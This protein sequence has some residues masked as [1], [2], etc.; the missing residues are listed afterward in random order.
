MTSPTIQPAQPAQPPPMPAHTSPPRRSGMKRSLKIFGVVSGGLVL[1][2][3]GVGIGAST[4][5]AAIIRTHTVVRTQ[6]VKVPG[7]TVTKTITVK[8][9]G[10]TVTQT[11]GPPPPSAT[12]PGDGTFV[13]GTASADWAPGTWQTSGPSASGDGNCYWATLSDLSGSFNSII[14]ND[15]TA[16]PTTLQ[17]VAGVAG[18][19]VSGCSTWNKIG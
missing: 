12:M 2:G 18:V 3:V 8:V 10:P 13:V 7:P 6:T 1:L 16:G 14:A 5:P 9:P 4:T 19:Q 15:N 11:A 17:V